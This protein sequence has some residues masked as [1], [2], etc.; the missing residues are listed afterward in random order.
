MFVD[1]EKAFDQVNRECIYRSLIAREIPEK[2]V[3]VIKESYNN[4]RC[5]VLHN[6]QLSDFYDV[7]QGVRQ[8]VVLSPILLVIDD[9]MNATVGTNERQAIQLSLFNELSHIGYPDN[10]C[11]MANN[12]AGLNQMCH[13]LQLNGE[14]AGLSTNTSKAKV[15]ATGFKHT[16]YSNSG[17]HSGG[18]DV[19]SRINVARR[20]FGILSPVRKTIRPMES[21]G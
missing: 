6:G 8:V 11:L 3:A 2:I 7:R 19:N 4:G 20:A 17:D 13:S 16:S 5:F 9:V 12:T 10:I 15:M 18:L 14:V 1:F 21:P